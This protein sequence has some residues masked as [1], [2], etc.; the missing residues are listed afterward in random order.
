L[1]DRGH[2]VEL[3]LLGAPG[4]PSEVAEAWVAAARTRE[5]A[6]ALSFSGVL[7]V[8][9]LSDALAACEVLLFVDPPGPTSRKTTLAASLAAGRAVLAL[10]G[11]RRW[12]RLIQADAA[13]VAEPTSL[14]V[15]DELDALLADESLRDALGARGRAFAE[16]NM[17]A[18]HSARVVADLLDGLL[19]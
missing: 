18:D 3:T 17:S 4:R 19:A 9:E 5:I 10:D 16:R 11:P 15:A 1:A 2:S 7:P 6:H 8:Q 12:S 14:A 13:R